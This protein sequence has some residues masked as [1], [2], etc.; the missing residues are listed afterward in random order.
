MIF[1]SIWT[2]HLHLVGLAAVVISEEIGKGFSAFYIYPPHSA[3]CWRVI[4]MNQ[5]MMGVDSRFRGTWLS[6]PGFLS[7]KRGMGFI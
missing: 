2:R 6:Y 1:L 5:G 3:F 4:I 7:R